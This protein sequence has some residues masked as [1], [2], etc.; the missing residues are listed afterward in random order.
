LIPLREK[1]GDPEVATWDMEKHSKPASAEARSIEEDMT[2][3]DGDRP[4]ALYSE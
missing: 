4:L 1:Y 3:I 2:F